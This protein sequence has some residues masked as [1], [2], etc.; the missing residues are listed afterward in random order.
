MHEVQQIQQTCKIRFHM[1]SNQIE[2]VWKFLEIVATA[3][4][5][6]LLYFGVLSP[7]TTPSPS[8]PHD[9]IFVYGFNIKRDGYFI[10]ALT[11]PPLT[12]IGYFVKGVPTPNPTRIFIGA[13]SPAP[14]AA[15]TTTTIDN[16]TGASRC[17]SGTTQNFCYTG[18]R[19]SGRSTVSIGSNSNGFDEFKRIDG[20]L[21]EFDDNDALFGS[22][23]YVLCFIIVYFVCNVFGLLVNF[24]FFFF[25]LF[26]FTSLV[27]VVF[28]MGGGS[29]PRLFDVSSVT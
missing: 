24:C 2:K 7:A 19:D 29:V 28:K 6:I 22:P 1:V 20:K 13:L 25:V 21:N 17:A 26:C 11:A 8:Q 16:N 12:F 14:E 23:S 15:V 3:T 18:A 4:I 10:G 27:C 9:I 5:V